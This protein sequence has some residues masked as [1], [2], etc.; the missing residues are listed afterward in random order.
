MRKLGKKNQVL[1]IIL[2]LITVF[3]IAIFIYVIMLMLRK[4][5]NTYELKKNS[6]LYN[7]DYEIID[8]Q[9]GLKLKKSFDGNYYLKDNRK[10]TKIGKNV[11][12]DNYGNHRLYLYGT[13]Y[14]VFTDGSIEKL[15]NENK[16]LKTPPTKF[17]KLGDRK[18][19]MVDDNISSSDSSIKTSGYLIVEINKEGNATLVNDKM[20]IKTINPIILYGSTF[21]FDI[22]NEKLIYHNQEIDLKNIIGSSNKYKKENKKEKKKENDN[23]TSTT[24]NTSSSNQNTSDYYENYLKDVINSYNNLYNSVSNINDSVATKVN[25]GDIYY[26]F[27]KWAVMKNILVSSTSI[28]INYNIYDPNDEYSS[29]FVYVTDKKNYDKRIE[30]NKNATSMSITNLDPNERYVI[31][32]GYVLSEDGREEVIDVSTVT[33]KTPNIELKITRVMKNKVYYT[34]NMDDKFTLLNSDLVLYNRDSKQMIKK[35]NI[36][37]I[38]KEYNG[39]IEYDSDINPNIQL[40][41]E[42]MCYNISDNKC[43]GYLTV[44]VSDAL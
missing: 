42:N 9:G 23:K 34:I 41:L 38:T 21:D 4:G 20:N 5:N 11:I 19:L 10:S 3:M 30:L 36:N 8:V 26:E 12:L 39:V 33:T 27:S 2:S 32:F 43:I 37:N 17:F 22:A 31:N 28:T 40:K 7:S 15:S 18:Y 25:K 16:V 13:L 6:Y 29:V 14:Q 44:N 1:F 35:D 24:D